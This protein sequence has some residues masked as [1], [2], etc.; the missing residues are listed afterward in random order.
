MRSI[1]TEGAAK[2]FALAADGFLE[3]PCPELGFPVLAR[4]F[5]E[6]GL[7]PERKRIG[8]LPVAAPQEPS[9]STLH[10]V[11]RAALHKG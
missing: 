6:G 10:G 8:K 5:T 2:R 11:G 4:L 1:E 9:F 7:R 3:K